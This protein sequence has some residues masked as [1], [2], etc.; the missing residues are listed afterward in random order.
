MSGMSRS[1]FLSYIVLSSL[2]P[3]GGG[4]AVRCSIPASD[5]GIEIVEMAGI[6]PASETNAGKMSTSLSGPKYRSVIQWSGDEMMDL[7]FLVFSLPS[8]EGKEQFGRFMP[9]KGA[10]HDPI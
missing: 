10:K 7:A 4:T 6:E 8:G 1:D 5:R 2:V 9:H 3:P